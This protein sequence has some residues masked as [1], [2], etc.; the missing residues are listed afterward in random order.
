MSP[1]IMTTTLP[2]PIT[3][4]AIAMP[5]PSKFPLAAIAERAFSPLMPP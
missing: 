2:N 5:W 3:I 4:A 1:R